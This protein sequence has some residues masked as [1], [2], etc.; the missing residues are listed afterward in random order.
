MD[1]KSWHLSAFFVAFRHSP[2]SPLGDLAF[3]HSPLSSPEGDLAF[4]HSLSFAAIPSLK[5]MALRLHPGLY[6]QN[7]WRGW[8]WFWVFVLGFWC[9][10]VYCHQGDGAV[11]ILCRPQSNV[12]VRERFSLWA[13]PGL[14][15]SVTSAKAEISGVFFLSKID[16]AGG[17]GSGCVSLDFS[18]RT[19]IATMGMVQ[20]RCSVGR[21]VMFWCA[22]DFRV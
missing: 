11:K 2:A 6:R 16:G 20:Q 1:R 12:L 17:V 3:R 10:N 9:A 18:A 4:R 21:R 15:A 7:R 8:C 19:C 14:L 5:P 13:G 22:N